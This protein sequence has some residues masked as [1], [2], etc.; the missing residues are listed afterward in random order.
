[1]LSLANLPLRRRAAAAAALAISLVALCAA[2]LPA[3]ARSAEPCNVVLIVA[4]DLGYGDLACFG[5]KTNRTPALD[6]MAAD[7]TKFTSFY[8][9]QAVCTASRAA[10][11]T[12]CYPN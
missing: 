10:L 6:R 5:S 3:T 7:G 1:M 2:F 8:A 4:D 12:G 11:M 9:A